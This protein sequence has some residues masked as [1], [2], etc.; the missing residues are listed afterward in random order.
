MRQYFGI[1]QR[2]TLKCVE[3]T[4]EAATL[5]TTDHFQLSCHIDKGAKT[6][7]LPFH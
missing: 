7:Q 6:V 1:Q 4:E 2:E 5:S 3:A